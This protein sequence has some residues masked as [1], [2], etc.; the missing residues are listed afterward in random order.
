[1]LSYYYAT[2]YKR[3]AIIN[4]IHSI[5]NSKHIQFFQYTSNIINDEANEFFHNHFVDLNV[6]PNFVSWAWLFPTFLTL[7]LQLISATPS[8]CKIDTYDVLCT[9][10][11]LNINNATA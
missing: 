8:G 6:Y 2:Q 11:V 1:M 5:L 3:H 4:T 7:S 10:M 9:S